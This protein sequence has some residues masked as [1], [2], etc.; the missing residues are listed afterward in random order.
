MSAGSTYPSFLFDPLRHWLDQ[1][2]P[3]PDSAALTAL[4]EQ[5]PRHVA[6]GQRIRFVPPQ[7]DGKAYECR[8][9]ERGE[10]ETRPDNWHDFFNAL[11]WLA[12]PHT[13]NAIS[14]AHVRGVRDE[15]ELVR[16]PLRVEL[17]GEPERVCDEDVVVGE[18]MED[19]HRPRAPSLRRV[20]HRR[21]AVVR[22]PA[23]ARHPE[24]P[25]AVVRVVE[26]VVRV[27]R[28]DDGAVEDVRSQE[29]RGRREHPAERPA[30]DRDAR[31]VEEPELRGGRLEGLDLI[32]ERHREVAGDTTL[33]REPAAGCA[34]SLD[35]EHGGAEFV[36]EPL[37]VEEPG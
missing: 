28:A 13:K 29:D 26:P 27:R 37:L 21:R 4:A 25:L 31:P 24:V 33:P 19:E 3:R 9:W 12:F 34:A 32:V 16:R 18:P 36:G 22:V 30:A 1:L 15:D 14:A 8:I 11:V 5:H 2:P 23:L 7:D 20:E 17:R 6:S 10:V 35:H